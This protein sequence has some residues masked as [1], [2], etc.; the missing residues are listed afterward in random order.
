MYMECTKYLVMEGEPHLGKIEEC[1]LIADDYEIEDMI[2]EQLYD[3]CDYPSDWKFYF[4]DENT[5]YDIEIDSKDYI[6]VEMVQEYFAGLEDGELI[7][8]V[9]LYARAGVDSPN[10]RSK[11]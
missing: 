11:K 9:E 10:A 7:N 3:D 6:D 4:P 2:I 1:E 5:G 8:I